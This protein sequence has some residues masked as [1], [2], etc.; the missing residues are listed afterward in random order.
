[1][2]WLLGQERKRRSANIAAPDPRATRPTGAAPAMASPPT[3]ASTKAAPAAL[4]I[5]SILRPA[6]TSVPAV[7]TFQRFLRP[8]ATSVPP[9]AT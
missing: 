7:T 4:T 8:A 3:T 5:W 6:A 2:Q 1:M 9:L